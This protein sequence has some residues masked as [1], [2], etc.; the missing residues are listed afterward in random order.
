MFGRNLSCFYTFHSY[1]ASLLWGSALIRIDSYSSARAADV[2]FL[3]QGMTIKLGRAVC[4][5]LL[6]L[7]FDPRALCS[8]ENRAWFHARHRVLV[9]NWLRSGSK[10][11]GWWFS[12][13]INREF[14]ERSFD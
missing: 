4:V 9:G 13:H 3:A 5:V 2:A 12:M 7:G 10:P 1:D 6:G 8:K 11:L 14:Q